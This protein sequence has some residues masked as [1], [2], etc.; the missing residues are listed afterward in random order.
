VR[1]AHDILAHLGQ[2]LLLTLPHIALPGPAARPAC[3]GPA[4]SANET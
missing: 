1:G 3:A 2:P 4:G